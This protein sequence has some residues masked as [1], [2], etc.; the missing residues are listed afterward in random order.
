MKGFSSKRSIGIVTAAA[1]ALAL[2]VPAAAALAAA[3]PQREAAALP[4]ITVTMNGKS[5]SVGGSLVSGGVKVVSKV[6][7]EASGNPT[8]VRLDPGVTVA[9]LLKA[10]S[11]DPNNIAL[12]A[13]VV[14]SPQANRGTSSAEVSL[15]PGN[16]VALDL[17]TSQSN[18]ALTTFTIS[19]SVSPASLPK[20][21]ATLSAI[22]F[23]FRGPSTLHDG[24]LVRFGNHGF[25][26]HMMFA[27][28][29]SSKARA[30]QVAALLKAGKDDKAEG[31]TDGS[32]LFFGLLTHDQSEQQI[33]SLRPGYWV[34]A[35]FMDTQDGREHTQLGMER[36]I[37]IVR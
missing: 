16:Y 18:P 23:G 37:H 11:G 6:S 13:S 31:M 35:C 24:E 29:A 10:G 5:I 32:Y 14:F 30:E 2:A 15:K 20:P 12:V 28:R 7:G 1:A 19:P 8:F 33:V 34:I 9:Q 27:G 4:V 26:V 21:R 3:R 36:V 22:E 25:L 17:N